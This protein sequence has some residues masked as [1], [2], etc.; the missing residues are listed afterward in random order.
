MVVMV[1]EDKK[2]NKGETG[3]LCKGNLPAPATW[4]R[5]EGHPERPS[6]RYCLTSS[7]S[8]DGSRAAPARVP[9][10]V[11]GILTRGAHAGQHQRHRSGCKGSK[12]G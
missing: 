5:W 1:W 10:A 3:V 9:P 2:G 6:A 4:R 11:A 12:R 7:P 8:D